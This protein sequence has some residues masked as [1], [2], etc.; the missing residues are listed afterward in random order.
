M[1]LSRVFAGWAPAVFVAL[2]VGTACQSVNSDPV[3]RRY[4]SVRQG[5]LTIQGAVEPRQIFSTTRRTQTQFRYCY[6][7]QLARDSSLQ[8]R[9]VVRFTIE[10]T[11]LVSNVVVQSTTVEN[12]ELETCLVRI[13]S[14]MQFPSPADGSKAVVSD[15]LLFSPGDPAPNELPAR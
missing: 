1:N 4:P 9:V 10:S 12:A 14:R 6:D 3:S 15:M 7:K 5:K 8:G 13:F 11:G 2:S